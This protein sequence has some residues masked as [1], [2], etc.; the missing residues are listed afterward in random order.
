MAVKYWTYGRNRVKLSTQWAAV[1]RRADNTVDFTINSGHRTFAQ[2]Q[3]LYDQNM[4][5]PGV[6][7]PNH[8]LTAVPSHSAPH[9]RTDRPD[10]ALDVNSRDGG[11]QRLQNWLN[12]HRGVRARGRAVNTVTNEAWHL[13]ISRASLAWLYFKYRRFRPRS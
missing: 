12:S 11:E 13:E 8:P 5:A 2:Q 7:K 4:I 3:A 10:H 1:L 9:I 6:P